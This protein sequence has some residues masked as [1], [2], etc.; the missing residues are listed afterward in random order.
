MFSVRDIPFTNWGITNEEFEPIDDDSKKCIKTCLD[1]A[2]PNCDGSWKTA[3]CN[4][5]IKYVCEGGCK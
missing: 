4:M 2:N 5:P 3:D 1:N